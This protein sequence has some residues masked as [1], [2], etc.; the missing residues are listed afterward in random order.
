M[1]DTETLTRDYIAA[2]NG[3]EWDTIKG[4]LDDAAT[5]HYNGG[6][7]HGPGEIVSLYQMLCDQL[8]WK[9]A[10]H[11]IAAT[12]TWAATLHRNELSV[13]SF[14]VCTSARL[15]DGKIVEMWTNGMPPL[16]AA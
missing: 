2:I 11:S 13:G 7:A 14:D 5:H 15:A 1:A 16:P 9:I 4:M 8:G 6:E 3:R 12:D 10:I